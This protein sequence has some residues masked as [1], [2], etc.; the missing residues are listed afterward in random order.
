MV[1]H[2]STSD[3]KSPQVS[4]SLLKILADLSNSVVWMVFPRSV[5]SKFPSLYTK[6]LVTIPSAPIKIGITV[7]FMFHSSLVRSRYVSLFVFFQFYPV[8]SRNSIVHSSAGSLFYWL[9]QGLVVWSRLGDTFVSQNPREFCEYHFLGC[10][11]IIFLGSNLDF[12]H[13][14][15]QITFPTQLRLV[16][17]IIK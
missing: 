13:N 9:S 8:V 16:F 14:C 4:R 5:I 6:Y 3:S 15:P 7:T 12:L 1:F 17:I 2:W 10:T 11:Y